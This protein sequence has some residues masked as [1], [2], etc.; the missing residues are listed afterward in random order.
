MHLKTLW[1][2]AFIA[3]VVPCNAPRI[4][5]A[6]TTSSFDTVVENVQPKIVKIYGAGGVRGLEA[7]QSGFLISADG[8]IVTASSYVLDPEYLLV[9]LNDGR[10][11]QAE[12]IGVDPRMEI[13]VLRI[14]AMEL[15]CF[16]LRDPAELE[17]GDRIL[18]FSNLFGVATGNEASSVLHG[19]VSAITPL[20]ARRGTF[21]SPY[22]GR[23][24]VLD[25]ITNNAGAAGGALTDRA[26]RIAGVLGK[27]LR[28]SES[29]LW[30]NYAIPATELYQSVQNILAGTVDRQTDLAERQPSD[31]PWTLTALGIRL[32]PNILPTTP[33]YVASVVP[34]SRAW[35]AGLR[36]DDLL[37]FVDDE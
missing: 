37:L 9:I 5:C 13:A 31:A 27:E 16:D 36:P 7:Y 17:T 34:E 18:A 14:P 21:T 3:T 6:I 1:L 30:L 4:V 11:F 20:S 22:H 26:G 33:P 19:S 15:P 23:I 12:I 24:F 10:K 32:V 25:A 28:S 35:H 8:L 2:V 29:N